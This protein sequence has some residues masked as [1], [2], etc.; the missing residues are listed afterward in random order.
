M[1]LVELLKEIETKVVNGRYINLSYARQIKRDELNKGFKDLEITKSTSGTVRLGVSYANMQRNVDKE[2]GPLPFGQWVE[3]YENL[4]IENK[5]KYYLRVYTTENP[6][7]TK[8]AYTMNGEN[9]TKQDLI[10]MGALKP[11]KPNEN[12]LFN[13]NIDSIV[14]IG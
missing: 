2:I 1:E 11:S 13:I 4:I 7:H 6:Y 14:S 8:V 5:G 9:Y 12:G 3:N 10:D